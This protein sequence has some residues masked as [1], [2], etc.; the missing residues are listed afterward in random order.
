MIAVD[1]SAL[2]AIALA[3]A[4]GPACL[5]ALRRKTQLLISA[6]T[7]VEALIVAH[8]RNVSDKVVALIDGLQFEI[9]TVTNASARR[10]ATAYRRW[11]KG[12]HPAALNYGDCFAYETATH[13]SCK[14]LYIGGD[15]AKT[16]V[17]SVLL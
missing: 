7:I 8:Q 17:Q 6:G 5:E 9:V 16:D 10:A 14:L 4:A 15:F 12:Q 2:L 11:G 3:E 1:T 13:H